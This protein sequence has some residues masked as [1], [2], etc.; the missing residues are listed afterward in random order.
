MIDSKISKYI[1]DRLSA[2]ATLDQ[3]TY[4]L[5]EKYG[6]RW[7]D[8]YSMVF[9]VKTEHAQDIAKRQ[10]PMMLGLALFTF[11]G[12]V[13]AIAWAIFELNIYA[14]I[15]I[16]ERALTG[17]S[18]NIMLTLVQTAPGYFGIIGMG[19]A[20]IVGSVIGMRQEWGKL[21]FGE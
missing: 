17:L 9:Y 14:N 10:F 7:D 4:S 13:G 15:L 20:M 3:I 12:G 11:V 18:A 16:A 1:L 8:A 5:C 6:L 19:L 21:L 2:H